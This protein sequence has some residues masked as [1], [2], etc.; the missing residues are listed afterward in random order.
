MP[1]PVMPSTKATPCRM[2]T[3]CP[4]RFQSLAFA[5]SAT[6]AATGTYSYLTDSDLISGMSASSG[7]HWSRTCAPEL[8]RW[9]NRDPIEEWGGANLY[10]FIGNEPVN[11]ID[12][13]GAI[14]V[15]GLTPLARRL[16]RE[17][18]SRVLQPRGWNVAAFLLNHSLQDSPTD[19]HFDQHHFVSMAIVDSAEYE[20]KLSEIVGNQQVGYQGYVTA[21]SI[22]FTT[23]D[24]FAAIH[25]A[26]FDYTGW[27]CKRS[28]TSYDMDL[29]ITIHD[30][31]N[32]H[33]LT[34]QY[35]TWDLEQILGTI[36]NNMAWS[37]QFFDVINN[38]SWDA[39]IH[40]Q[41]SR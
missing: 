18:M 10:A 33:L 30:D 38:Y 37:D 39:S 32:F 2:L 8:T 25:A 31:Y 29:H 7:F 3:T 21:D 19:L 1:C 22:A 36:A 11:S 20:N 23:G 6:S 4:A 12:L 35:F 34:R 13:L 15:P 41:R 40:E 24:L 9:L 26:S 28:D 17:V 14:R 27:V 5:S 16:W